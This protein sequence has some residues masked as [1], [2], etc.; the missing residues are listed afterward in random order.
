M[1]KS[2]NLTIQDVARKAG[3]STATVSRVLNSPNVVSKD[4]NEKV[5]RAINELGYRPNRAARN[6][7]AGKVQKV[8]VV[9]ADIRNPFFTSI[10]AGIESILQNADHVLI[11]GNS[12]EDPNLE[13]IHLE[14]LIDEG[15]AGIIF[16]ATTDQ[17]RRYAFVQEAGIPLL[18]VDRVPGQL[19]VDSVVVNNKDAAYQATNHLVKLGHN[20]IAFIGGPSHLS[21]A[22]ERLRGYCQALNENEIPCNSDFIVES[23]FKQQGGY[24]AMGILWRNLDKPT[25][26][27][28]ANNLMTLGAYEFIHENH[29][30]VPTEISVVG[31]DD[32]P[33]ATSLQPPLTVIAQ[34]TLEMGRIAAKLLLDRIKNPESPIQKIILETQLIVRKS[35]GQI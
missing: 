27:L 19:R 22:H 29:I 26:V 32:M 30:M 7:R 33:W 10:L 24:D 28:V 15:V 35:C 23:N 8:G 21:T 3:V 25:A 14:T 5:S 4:L 9:F 12:N 6:L 16:T 2:A 17:A 20:K 13:K 1:R 34:P 11:L 31:F 18:A